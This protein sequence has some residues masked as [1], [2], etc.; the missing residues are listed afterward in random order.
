MI[1]YIP[2]TKTKQV[3]VV[4]EIVGLVSPDATLCPNPWG[5]KLWSSLGGSLVPHPSKREGWTPTDACIKT[6]IGTVHPRHR[7]TPLIQQLFAIP[8]HISQMRK[9]IKRGRRAVDVIILLNSFGRNV[10]VSVPRN[11]YKFC[12]SDSCL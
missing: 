9:C 7:L 8:N 5:Q 4:Q 2:Q 1:G 11:V 12:S 10:M 6:G 3:S